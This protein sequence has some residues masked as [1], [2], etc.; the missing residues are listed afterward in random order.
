MGFPLPLRSTR[1]IS[2]DGDAPFIVGALFTPDYID[3]AN[4]LILSLRRLSL[5]FEAHEVPAV[6][7][8]MSASGTH[9]LSYTKPNFI[10]HML[11][12]H[13]KPVLYL[14]ADCEVLSAPKLIYELATSRCDF[15]IYN[16]MA[17][18]YRD[19]FVPLGFGTHPPSQAPYRYFVYHGS[20]DFHSKDQL[21]AA[22][23]TQLY[24][25]TK[26]ARAL[27]SAWQRTIDTFPGAGDDDCLDFTYNNL[28]KF[29]PLYWFLKG[30][31]LPKGY[32]RYMF[33][34]YAEPI[35]NHPDIP[36]PTSRFVQIRC[37]RGRQR[38][39]A[40]RAEQRNIPR[41]LPRHDIIDAQEGA[42]C[43]MVNGEVM[44]IGK[45]K[46]RFWV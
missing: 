26:A 10:R 11:D 1:I 27:L 7:C 24:R 14:D 3:K 42:I 18:D 36:A 12:R 23:C 13:R 45:I 29:S 19:R 5:P 46:M 33:W 21:I 8:S 6:H 20:L 17:D 43:R 25:N 30:R 37:S 15:A 2:G 35:I 39:Y 31:W 44:P 40:K 9:D 4:R 32:A 34:I 22:G 38:V 28:S 41:P 16:W